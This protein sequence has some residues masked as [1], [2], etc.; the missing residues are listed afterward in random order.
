M[1]KKSRSGPLFITAAATLW[2]FAGVCVK[3]IPWS[4]LSLVCFRSIC[5]SIMFLTYLRFPKIKFTKHNVA[6]AVALLLTSVM[7]ILANKLTTAANAIVLHYTAPLFVLLYGLIFKKRKPTKRDIIMCVTVITGC[8]IS[9]ADKLEGGALLGNIL[10]LAS[11]VTFAS[12]M[13]INN[14]EKT[15][16]LQ[17]QLIGNILMSVIFLP[18]LLTDNAITPDIKTWGAA[19][20]LGFIQYGLSHIIFGVGIKRIEASSASLISTVEPILSPVWVFLVIGE[21]PGALT[22][23]GFVIVMAAVVLYNISLLR[24]E[25]RE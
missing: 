3:Y 18:A 8:V 22:I 12:I 25:K 11:G 1:D 7:F 21:K 13:I 10:A 14:M 6:G 4:A 23:A 19:L 16:S 5:A 2:S 15:D 17:S 20:F 24:A 9:C